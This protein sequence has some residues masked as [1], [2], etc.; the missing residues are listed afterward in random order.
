MIRNLVFAG[1][2]LA[3]ASL[4]GAC[5]SP[6][7]PSQLTCGTGGECPPDQSCHAASNTCLTQ[8]QLAEVPDVPDAGMCDEGYEGTPGS[9]T[10]IDECAAETDDCDGFADCTNT[11][12]GA[13]SRST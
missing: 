2:M 13:S 6:T 10:D 11:N 7:Y 3:T 1:V 8:E 5:F 12:G 4:I 9:C